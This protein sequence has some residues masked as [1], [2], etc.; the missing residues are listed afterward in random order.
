MSSA[1][2]IVK[3][4]DILPPV[5]L[6]SIQE[7]E[8]LCFRHDLKIDSFTGLR[9]ITSYQEPLQGIRTTETEYM[10]RDDE[11]ARE[12]EKLFADRADLRCLARHLL[13]CVSL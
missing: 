5:R 3:A 11:K 7:I 2:P 12:L 8:E 4:Y 10:L 6:Y 1:E 9:Y 13:V